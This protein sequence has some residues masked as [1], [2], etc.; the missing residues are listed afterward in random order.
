MAFV[1]S[2][3]EL[4]LALLQATTSVMDKMT[5]L[6]SSFIETRNHSCDIVM[7]KGRVKN[8]QALMSFTVEANTLNAGGNLFGGYVSSQA[9]TATARLML[10]C[11]L[12]AERMFIPTMSV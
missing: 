12:R 7:E 6:R 11:N 9:D 3:P 5:K 8:A 10:T 1:S 4:D 2:T